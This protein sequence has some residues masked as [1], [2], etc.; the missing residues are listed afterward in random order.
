MLTT[1]CCCC[2]ILP[3]STTAPTHHVSICKTIFFSKFSK[4]KFFKI[5]GALSRGL[6]GSS[7]PFS[8]SPPPATY[9]QIFPDLSTSFLSPS[10]S[11]TPD[12]STYF[13]TSFF[14]ALYSVFNFSPQSM[15]DR[16]GP[17]TTMAAH[18]DALLRLR[19]T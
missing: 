5:F 12:V 1:C 9:P 8:N 6:R 10:Y 4:I 17:H 18:R 2:S 13:H 16:R 14:T 7:P 11:D 3:N 15:S 19:L